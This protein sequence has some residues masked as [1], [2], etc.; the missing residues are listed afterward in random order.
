MFTV[1]KKIKDQDFFSQKNNSYKTLKIL[2]IIKYII[3]NKI[4]KIQRIKK[5]RMNFK[6]SKLWI[7]FYH[8]LD[9]LSYGIARCYYVN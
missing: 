7:F 5:I 6:I 2:I 8:F 4:H 3:I 9:L 1:W